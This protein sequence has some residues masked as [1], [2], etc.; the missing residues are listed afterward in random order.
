MIGLI[1]K[2][3]HYSHTELW[4]FPLVCLLI[5]G[6]SWIRFS[7]KNLDHLCCCHCCYKL[8]QV[9]TGN[10]TVF[11][12]SHVALLFKQW[13]GRKCIMSTELLAFMFTRFV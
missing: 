12:I 13:M 6:R 1:R 2:M 11:K 10:I 8:I 5:M 7:T 3:L 4:W 9:Q